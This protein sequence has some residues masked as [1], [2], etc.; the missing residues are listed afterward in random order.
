M[1][2]DPM[3]YCPAIDQIDAVI[4]L[5]RAKRDFQDAKHGGP[6][7]DDT[8]HHWDW[9][10]FIRSYVEAAE[11][12][13]YVAIACEKQGADAIPDWE[14]YEENLVDVAALAIAAIQ[15]IRRKTKAQL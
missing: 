13:G 3:G 6:T 12:Y 5:I 4:A 15:S 1:N 14:R 8:H 9:I 10:Y 2:Q 7:H 11:R